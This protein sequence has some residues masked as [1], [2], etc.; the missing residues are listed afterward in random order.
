MLYRTKN[1][2]WDI[3]TENSNNS[4][5][6]IAYNNPEFTQSNNEE[7]NSEQN[8]LWEDID[9]SNLF[10]DIFNEEW[11]NNEEDNNEEL[12]KT[13]NKEE[14]NNNKQ[15][16]SKEE[17]NQQSN[18][19]NENTE[20]NKETVNTKE[21]N[22]SKEK[23]EWNE[24]WTW[25]KIEKY[26]EMI[27]NELSIIPIANNIILAKIRF[28]W[29]SWDIYNLTKVKFKL[30]WLIDKN[31]IDGVYLVDKFWRV[32]WNIKQFNSNWEV[33]NH[34]YSNSVKNRK[35]DKE[36]NEIYLAIDLAKWWQWQSLKIKTTLT[37]DKE[38]NGFAWSW[39]VEVN[40]NTITFTTKEFKTS[41]YKSQVINVYWYDITNE[42]YVWDENVL[43]WQIR[44]SVWDWESTKDVKLKK[45]ILYN[46]SNKAEWIVNNVIIKDDSW[47]IV[48]KQEKIVDDYVIMKFNDNYKMSDWE[49]K[50]FYIYWDI[51][52][53][54]NN[55]EIKFTLD[56][57]RDLIAVEASDDNIPARIKLNS[58]YYFGTYKI[59]AWK[60][61]IIKIPNSPTPTDVASDSQWY[62]VLRF[63]IHAPSNIT[64]DKFKVKMKIKSSKKTEISK[65]FDDVLL[66][67]C[68][69]TYENCE[70]L[71]TFSLDNDV[72]ETGSICEKLIPIYVSDIPKWNNYYELRVNISRYAPE[73]TEFSFAVNSNSLE[74]AENEN[75][76]N[77]ST[78]DINGSAESW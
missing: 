44:I 56:E 17:K 38:L 14:E 13:E 16:N 24:E 65:I 43:I 37:F 57:E 39:G 4:N 18:E 5:N 28:N 70:S 58:P 54:D 34:F 2:V 45:I 51:V 3:N 23:D 40:W 29:L 61:A 69:E 53:W 32:I 74:W 75:W 73:K 47:N 67:K 15:E 1:K 48:A 10:S 50:Q 41:D 36:N 46:V 19:E 71:W 12:T 8:N 22:L 35:I 63:K 60:V 72:I 77:I 42:L 27:N 30:L 21:Q 78:D 31:K 7:K 62:V 55:D 49:T 9:L 6:N 11:N 76:D 68:D 52:W 33:E 25:T 64:I 59:K 20:Q 66:Y 26:I